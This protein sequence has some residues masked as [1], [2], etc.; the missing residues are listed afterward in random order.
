MVVEKT[1][2][3]TPEE[4][5][6]ASQFFGKKLVGFTGGTRISPPQVA[7]NLPSILL[8]MDVP[9]GDKVVAAWGG[10][11]MARPEILKRATALLER[12][13][14]DSFT[15]EQAGEFCARMV[16][17]NQ[18]SGKPIGVGVIKTLALVAP[19]LKEQ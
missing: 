12:T 15:Q 5:K 1:A 4:L 17:G 6:L 19:K 10:E 7:E 16:M 2:Q 18:H 8:Y 14:A 11:D 3:V 9:N 13:K